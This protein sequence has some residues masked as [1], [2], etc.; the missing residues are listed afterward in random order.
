MCSTKSKYAKRR[1]HYHKISHG[2]DIT[3]IDHEAVDETVRPF[4]REAT[5]LLLIINSVKTKYMMADKKRFSPS[6]VGAE[7]GLDKKRSE[8][9]K[10]YL[11]LSYS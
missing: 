1:Y 2:I 3:N 9:V 8:K 6:A 10:E 4:K 5:R 7:M 11:V